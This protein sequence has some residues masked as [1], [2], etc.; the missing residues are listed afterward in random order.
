MGTVSALP[1]GPERSPVLLAEIDN[2]ILS[3]GFDSAGEVYVLPVG[4]PI[5]QLVPAERP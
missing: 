3:L 4:G 5:F 1:P 2:V